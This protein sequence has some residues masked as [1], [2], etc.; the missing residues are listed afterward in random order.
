[1]STEIQLPR[2]HTVIEHNSNMISQQTNALAKLLSP[3][4][5]GNGK[6]YIEY[7]SKLTGKICWTNGGC[8]ILIM[9]SFTGTC[10][11]V[12]WPCHPSAGH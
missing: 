5:S 7:R 4:P 8:N 9:N 3:R 1:M 10:K 6:G 2:T 12:K 11:P